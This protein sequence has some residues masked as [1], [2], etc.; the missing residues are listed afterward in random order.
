M[1]PYIEIQLW[2]DFH[3]T[4]I[5]VLRESLWPR[6]RPRSVGRVEERVYVERRPDAHHVIVPDVTMLE[7]EV[8]RLID[9]PIHLW[10]GTRKVGLQLTT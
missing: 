5:T 6:V 4:L 10:G 7:H 1:D 9:S 2:Q 8:A 3:H